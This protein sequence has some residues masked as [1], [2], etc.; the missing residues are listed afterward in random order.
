MIVSNGC[1]CDALA[2]LN[3]MVCRLALELVLAGVTVLTTM[4]CVEADDDAIVIT[5]PGF[6][7]PGQVKT[8]S[9]E[10]IS[11][12]QITVYD[13]ATHGLTP[14]RLNV[15]EYDGNFYEPAPNRLSPYS[16]TSQWPKTSKGSRKD[17]GPIRYGG[18]WSAGCTR[19]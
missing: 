7:Q 4:P 18:C 11:Q 8:A 2:V 1:D 6:T 5:P 19:H 17:K 12:L 10:T 16:L 14:C 3:D 13:R 9:G 15:I